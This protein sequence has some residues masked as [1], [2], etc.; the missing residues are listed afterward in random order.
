MVGVLLLSFAASRG[1]PRDRTIVLLAAIPFLV[2]PLIL[3]SRGSLVGLIA[4]VAVFSYS[5]NQN[6]SHT[7]LA[8]VLT[9]GAVTLL[10]A[11]AARSQ[12]W[13]VWRRIVGSFDSVDATAGRLGLYEL[14]ISMI[15]DHALLGFGPGI[16]NEQLFSAT[17]IAYSHNV[18]LDVFGQAG[19]V[20]GA[21]Y[22]ICCS[23]GRINLQQ[24]AGAALVAL[25][26]IS[27]VEPVITTPAGAILYIALVGVSRQTDST[28]KPQQRKT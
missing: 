7:R 24:P 10:L 11:F 26:A 12:D 9:V 20:I 21:A 25:L 5:R 3:A 6:H 27:M 2:A 16:F 8:R 28:W 14:S 4:G 13:F 22:I 19:I 1:R 15:S 23:P 18:L 17:G